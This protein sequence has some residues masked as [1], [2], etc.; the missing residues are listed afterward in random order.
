M[1]PYPGIEQTSTVNV[2]ARTLDHLFIEHGLQYSDYNFLCLDIQGAGLLALGGGLR[3][4]QSIE[5]VQTEVNLEE[6]YEGCALFRDIEFF[7]RALGFNRA[8]IV[9]PYHPS[10]GDAL[11]IRRPLVAMSSLGKNGRFG[12]QLFQYFHLSLL[13]ET[14]DAIVQTTPW[15]G[16]SLFA[17]KDTHPIIDS[18]LMCE[19][20]RGVKLNECFGIQFDPL[21]L[22]NRDVSLPVSTDFIGYFQFHTSVIA[23]RKD[24]FRRTFRF[25]TDFDKLLSDLYGTIALGGRKDIAVHLRRGDYGYGCFYKAPA[26]WYE[27]WLHVHSIDPTEFVVYVASEEAERFRSRFRSYHLLT[28]TDLPIQRTEMALMLL[29]FYVMTRADIL[30]ISNSSFSFSAAMLNA[31]CQQFLRPNLERKCLVSFDPWNSEVLE[32]TLLTPEEHASLNELDDQ[33]GQGHYDSFR[34]TFS[35]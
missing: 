2:T 34:P 35:Q 32:T 26:V 18:P 29:D 3:V 24:L 6:L 28:A 25:S 21:S 23:H 16:Q 10:W 27:R 13:A 9:T 8:T 20:N 19:A 30:C 1:E 14:H 15:V 17:L 7:M 31:K 11:Y 4:L 22:I 33:Q 12:N 5:A